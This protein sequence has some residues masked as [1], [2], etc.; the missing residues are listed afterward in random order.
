[1]PV[2]IDALVSAGFPRE[3]FP[4]DLPVPCEENIT[5][6]PMDGSHELY[7]YQAVMGGKPF[8]MEIVV[9]RGTLDNPAEGVGFML[10]QFAYLWRMDRIKLEC[11]AEGACRRINF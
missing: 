9:D 4:E 7:R 5:M 10:N 11:T 6:T 8:A 2:T 1:M 3:N